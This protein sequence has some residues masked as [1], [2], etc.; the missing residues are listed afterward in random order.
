MI[1]CAIPKQT[2]ITDT[3]IKTAPIVTNPVYSPS[4]NND[5]ANDKSVMKSNKFN[6]TQN[7]TTTTDM[8]SIL[9]CHN[10]GIA[11]F[12]E[13]LKRELVELS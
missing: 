6:T 4:D 10:G 9:L 13:R 7:T 2:P 3:A 11:F 8:F 1:I 12:V 5:I